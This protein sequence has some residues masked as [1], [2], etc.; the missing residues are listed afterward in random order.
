MAGEAFGSF[1]LCRHRYGC[2]PFSAGLI[3]NR[4]MAD[5]KISQDYVDGFIAR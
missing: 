5:R 2:F 1:S 4:K 3:L